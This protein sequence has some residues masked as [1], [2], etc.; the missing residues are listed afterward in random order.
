MK[1]PGVERAVIDPGKIRD[2]LLSNEHLIGRHK[3]AIFRGMGYSREDWQQL[4][5]D[6]LKL[7]QSSEA[8]LQERTEYGQKYTVDG[9]LQGPGPRVMHT[10]TAWIVRV[11]EDFQRFIT[12]FPRE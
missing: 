2:Y 12:A 9:Y 5:D 7:V 3:A 8:T 10:R 6:L 4:A 1:L 11:G